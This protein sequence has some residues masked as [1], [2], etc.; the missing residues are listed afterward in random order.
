M[1]HNTAS[2]STIQ[3]SLNAASFSSGANNGAWV[4]ITKIKGEALVAI[5]LGAVTGS[6]VVKVQD[7]TD[8]SGTG[9]ADLTG[10]VTPSL[11][12]ANTA[13]TLRIPSNNHRGFVRVVATVTTGPVLLSATI[14]GHPGIV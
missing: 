2:A 9:S 13:T 7:A 4:D 1:L 8:I 12:T 3:P 11:S 10:I 6:V 14:A 5:S